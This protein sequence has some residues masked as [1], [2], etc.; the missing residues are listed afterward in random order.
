MCLALL[1]AVFNDLGLYY[2]ERHFEIYPLTNFYTS[3]TNRNQKD[4]FKKWGI[5]LLLLFSFKYYYM[6]NKTSLYV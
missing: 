6:I 5:K 4:N 2:T 3:P 1:D